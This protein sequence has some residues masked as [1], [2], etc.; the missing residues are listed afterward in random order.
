MEARRRYTKKVDDSTV[1]EAAISE[2][3]AIVQEG[4][5]EYE[6][7]CQAYDRA[8][9]VGPRNEEVFRLKMQSQLK[10]GRAE[11]TAN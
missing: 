4:L 6:D 1:N 7:A 5:G 2:Q 10:I 8:I 3:L 11:D 9:E